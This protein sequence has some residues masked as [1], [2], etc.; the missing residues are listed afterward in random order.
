[1]C[2]VSVLLTMF[3]FFLL[4]RRISR[5]KRILADGPRAEA[6]VLDIDFEK[7]RGRVEFEYSHDGQKYKTATAIM[8]NKQTEELAAGDEIEV[9]VDPT[10]PR[11][12]LIVELY[13]G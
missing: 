11:R 5:I 1:M 3:L 13:C 12:A 9:A 6:T 4:A 2:A 7:D 8:K 10:N